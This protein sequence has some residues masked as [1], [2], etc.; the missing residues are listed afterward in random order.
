MKLAELL[1]A[2]ELCLFLGAGCND[3]L[4][5]PL[6]WQLAKKCR[7]SVS[8]P[9]DAINKGASTETLLE[10]LE[11]FR[12]KAM[13]SGEEFFFAKV[14]EA[15]Y[16]GF[17]VEENALV[18][19]PLLSALGAMMMGSKRGSVREV[20]TLNFDNVLETYLGLHGFVARPVYRY[21]Q[22]LPDNDVTIYHPHGFVPHPTS[23]A[24]RSD[25]LILDQYSYD[26]RHGRDWNPWLEVTRRLI[27]SKVFLAVGL[28]GKDP[29]MRELL[30]DAGE[31]LRDERPSGFWVLRSK[32]ELLDTSAD[33]QPNEDNG[34]ET[35]PTV[36]N[37]D[38]PDAIGNNTGEG[39][40]IEISD[41][42]MNMVRRNIV[43]LH[44]PNFDMCP[45]FLLD[46]CQTAARSMVRQRQH[47]AHPHV[48]RSAPVSGTGP[49]PPGSQPPGPSVPSS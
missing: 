34:N 28:S 40:I 14:A 4:G 20:L 35:Q 24:N 10:K 30:T 5:L 1:R 18:M 15:L 8:L 33:I 46:I 44:F 9:V 12:F 26:K 38:D 37:V 27:E 48:V 29:I 3:K 49:V 45:S 22:L 25:F 42:D 19:H 6:W 21:P 11:E 43:P 39:G 13:E 36:K 41:I 16:G 31:R 47:Q 2:G 23:E 32:Q 17:H 7:E